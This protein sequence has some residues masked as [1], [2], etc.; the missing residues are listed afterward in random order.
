MAKN[1]MVNAFQD[2]YRNPRMNGSFDFGYTGSGVVVDNR[3]LLEIPATVD[4]KT[5][6]SIKQYSRLP[7]FVPEIRKKLGLKTVFQSALS[8]KETVEHVG[9]FLEYDSTSKEITKIEVFSAQHQGMFDA[10]W[11]LSSKK[12]DIYFLFKRAISIN[13]K[14]YPFKNP[15]KTAH[16]DLYFSRKTGITGLI[17]TS[18]YV[19]EYVDDIVLDNPLLKIAKGK[20]ASEMIDLAFYMK[21]K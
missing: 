2:L 9:L 13:A 11:G 21:R 5:L 4:K 17:R 3:L 10:Y 16:A 1:M 18:D 12:A 14:E 8:R 6:E 7:P 15:D 20:P 19:S